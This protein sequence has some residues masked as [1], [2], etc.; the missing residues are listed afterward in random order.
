MVLVAV[1]IVEVFKAV[2]TVTLATVG[3]LFTEIT[4]KKSAALTIVGS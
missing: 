2:V 4:L 1:F 3:E